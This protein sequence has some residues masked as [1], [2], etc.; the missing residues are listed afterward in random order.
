MDFGKIFMNWWPIGLAAGATSLLAANVIKYVP[1]L[2]VNF[3]TIDVRT[4]IAT[5]I[6]PTFGNQVVDFFKG[7]IPTS[8]GG[9]LALALT[10]ILLVFLGRIIFEGLG[11]LGMKTDK[12]TKLTFVLLYAGLA[13]VLL[14]AFF[15]KIPIAIASIATLIY[16]VVI[17]VVLWLVSEYTGIIKVPEY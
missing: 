15:L 5:G 6:N 8:I 9:Y 1:A 12:Q 16:F 3:A 10:T 14:G 7:T 4:E 17:A 13:S 11:T 2:T